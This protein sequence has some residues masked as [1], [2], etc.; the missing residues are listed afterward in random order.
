ML[1]KW[2]IYRIVHRSYVV[3]A[4]ANVSLT[5]YEM[6]GITPN[7]SQFILITDLIERVTDMVTSST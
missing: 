5:L 4:R 6:S 3:S 1:F 2:T 7:Y